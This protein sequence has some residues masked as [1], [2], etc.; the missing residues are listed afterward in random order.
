MEN[1]ADGLKSLLDENGKLPA[2][3]WPGGYPLFYLDSEGNVSCPDCAN[4]NDEYTAPIVAYDANYEDDSLYC[5]H[6]SSRIV[7]AYGENS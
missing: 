3:A 7:S 5:D 4:N 6:C 2:Y 1:L